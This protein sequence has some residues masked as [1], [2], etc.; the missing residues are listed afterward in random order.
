M[1]ER[2]D[3]PLPGGGAGRAAG[4]ASDGA[5]LTREGGRPLSAVVAGQA[6]GTG[7]QVASGAP[8]RGSG[9]RAPDQDSDL[10][11]LLPLKLPRLPGELAERHPGADDRADDGYP[12]GYVAPRDRVVRVRDGLSVRELPPAAI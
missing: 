3:L 7:L 6:R 1:C 12:G 10:I 11:G 8:G 2:A 5:V 4:W 9:R